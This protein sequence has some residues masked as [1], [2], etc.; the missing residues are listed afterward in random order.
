MYKDVEAIVEQVNKKILADLEKKD[1]NWIKS[2]TCKKYQSLDGHFYSGFNTLWLSLQPF[3]RDIYGTYLQWKSKGCQV[4]KGS[5]SI[6]LLLYRPYEK[7]VEKNDGSKETKFIRLLRTFNVF[8][9]E[10]VKGDISKWDNVEK[11]DI[12]SVKNIKHAEEFIDNTRAQVSYVMDSPRA[13]YN[14]Q[15]DKITM[16]VKSQFIDT[17]NSDSTQNFYGVIFHELTHWTGHDKRCNRLLGNVFGSPKYAFEELI[18]E[19]GSAYVCNS[20][21]ISVSPRADHA[22]YISSWMRAIKDNKQA[23]LKASGLANKA[24]MFLNGLQPEQVKKVA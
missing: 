8:N 21:D 2:W 7:E 6:K 13:C 3:K 23:L 20:L 24:L 16:P 15:S 18:A 17:K 11:R 12:N 1:T 9:I 19:L 4:K 10:Q 5:Q 14:S 22:Q